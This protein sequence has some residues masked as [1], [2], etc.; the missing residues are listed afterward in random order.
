MKTIICILAI[1][2]C[3]S[4]HAT[5]WTVHGAAGTNPWIGFERVGDTGTTQ[6]FITLQYGT[7]SDYSEFFDGWLAQYEVWDGV[8]WQTS[9]WY[10]WTNGPVAT[11]SEIWIT[12]GIPYNPQWGGGTSSINWFIEDGPPNFNGGSSFDM[13]DAIPGEYW[14]DWSADG[15]IRIVQ[16]APFDF[17][18]WL[19]DG[20]INPSW[21]EPPLAPVQQGKR[22]AK[23]HN[24]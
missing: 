2:C 4:T 5:D 22:L 12:S 18:K 16:T 1:L 20:S 3:I 19:S 24:K 7:T 15:V 21:V 14:V 10:V 23:G 8:T 13:V 9:D 6:E 17:G 11:V